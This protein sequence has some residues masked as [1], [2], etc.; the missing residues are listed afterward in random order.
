M[1]FCPSCGTTILNP[2]SICPTCGGASRYFQYKC[3]Q[4]GTVYRRSSAYTG[5]AYCPTCGK[6]AIPD[7]QYCLN[8]SK[9]ATQPNPNGIV[10][11]TALIFWNLPVGTK[12]YGVHEADE[13]EA[14]SEGYYDTNYYICEWM[15]VRP[16]VCDEYGNANE[17]VFAKADGSVGDKTYS[18]VIW[19]RYAHNLELKVN[20]FLTEQE[21]E[22]YIQQRRIMD[23]LSQ[24]M[25]REDQI[26][27]I[28]GI[29][30]ENNNA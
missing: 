5:G 19:P 18:F 8:A 13:E 12:V 27:R 29:I 10:P 21:A 4:C 6:R 7:S 22:R 26:E 17:L 30:N 3:D 15:Y 25:L 9:I 28:Y 20:L 24:T 2:Y 23:R 11:T 16:G 14:S 1:I